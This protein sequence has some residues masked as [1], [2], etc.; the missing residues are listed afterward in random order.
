LRWPL[1]LQHEQYPLLTTVATIGPAVFVL[2]AAAPTLL[3]WPQYARRAGDAAARLTNRA[4]RI[5][6]RGPVTWAGDTVVDSHDDRRDGTT[7]AV[8]GGSIVGQLSVFG[9]ASLRAVG[10]PPARSRWRCSPPGHW[11]A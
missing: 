11:C 10:V 4:L 8:D 2:A 1:S 6:K 9:S 7:T 3:A 5:L